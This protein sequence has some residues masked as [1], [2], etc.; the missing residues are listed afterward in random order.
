M[1]I[2]H[3]VVWAKGIE[4]NEER[5]IER[6]MAGGRDEKTKTDRR[7]FVWVFNANNKD[8]Q[9]HRWLNGAL[10]AFISAEE[11][12]SFILSFFFN[13]RIRKYRLHSVVS[14]DSV[15][16]TIIKH[17]SFFHRIIIIITLLFLL[18]LVV[19]VERER[20]REH[21]GPNEIYSKR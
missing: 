13:L 9:I 5:G 1:R 10:D 8:F 2:I 19:E 6:E 4:M 18:P 14:I 21:N 7:R 3:V 15:R 17:Y 12:Q 11:C 16:R 20:M